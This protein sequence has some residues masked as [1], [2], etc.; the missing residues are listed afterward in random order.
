[1]LVG[2]LAIPLYLLIP[3]VSGKIS[4]SAIS[5]LFS[6]MDKIYFKLDIVAQIVYMWSLGTITLFFMALVANI[7][8]ILLI[9]IKVNIILLVIYGLINKD[10]KF[11]NYK[12]IILR[13]SNK[14]PILLVIIGIVV[15][16]LVSAYSPY[17]L[18][19]ES[20]QFRHNLYAIDSIEHNDLKFQIPYPPIFNT[21]LIY[22][23]TV[24]NAYSNSYSLFWGARFLMYI[25]YPIGI[26]LFSYTLSNNIKVAVVASV[27]GSFVAMDQFERYILAP[28]GI[29]YIMVPFIF[30]LA[31]VCI[32]HKPI[33]NATIAKNYTMVM[34]FIFIS[35]FSLM[36]AYRNLFLIN[37]WII[38][39][40]S[41]GLPIFSLLILY[42]FDK[43]FD[44]PLKLNLLLYL[45]IALV[46]I[47][48][49]IPM[50]GSVLFFLTI[51]LCL[52]TFWNNLFIRR[53]IYFSFIASY[54]F[55]F[56]QMFEVLE[57]NSFVDVYSVGHGGLKNCSE[58]FDIIMGNYS[59]IVLT[60]FI[61]GNIHALIKGTEKN[62]LSAIIIAYVFIIYFLP[63]THVYRIMVIATPFIAH[64]AA[65]MFIKIIPKDRKLNLIILTTI[66]T[67]FLYTPYL[68]DINSIVLKEDSNYYSLY[69]PYEYN[70]AKWIQS[71]IDTQNSYIISDSFTYYMITGIANTNDAIH[72]QSQSDVQDSIS[73][74][75]LA[76]N[77]TIF[78]NLLDK[79]T[80]HDE[81]AII[82][83]TG[84]TSK[85]LKYRPRG[86]V[87]T[88][89]YPSNLEKLPY[90]DKF[91]ESLFKPLYLTDKV[92]IYGL[93]KSSAHSM[94]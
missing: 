89:N 43:F 36:M 42:V 78:L 33:R 69:E 70:A 40:I 71:N 3:Y 65:Y 9:S 29:I 55:V 19:L 39:L 91:N 68:T 7:F 73:D 62:K 47:L 57:L 21:L 34:L 82:V 85:W 80:T 11:K 63:I 32:S 1:M 4:H 74:I 13:I 25:V 59:S 27:I 31:D 45:I 10:T 84:R 49:H 18:M 2:I 48:W 38:P 15:V 26:F 44:E 35:L 67:L 92:H 41:F 56:L 54:L 5:Y 37:E 20:D 61:I 72:M 52:K 28:K 30:Y 81:N 24:M 12:F 88:I 16:L 87:L 51:Y 66:F 58:K 14:I 77:S 22:I 8:G 90:M 93:N 64:F 86:E 79:S 17:P 60:L 46:L 50:G 94:E 53:I 76:K 75:L 23:I 6:W 83:I